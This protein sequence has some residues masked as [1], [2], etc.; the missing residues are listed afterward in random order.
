MKFENFTIHTIQGYIETIFI[1]EYKDKLLLLD[2]GCSSDVQLI[3]NFVVNTLKRPLTDIKLSFISHAH[4]DHAG[5]APILREKF[6]IQ[7]ASHHEID[8][9]Y[10]GFG[11]FLQQKTDIMLG[12]FVAIRGGQK[13]KLNINYSRTINPNHKLNNNDLLPG[14]RDWRAIHSPGHTSHDMVLYNE[15]EKILYAADIILKVGKKCVL[16]F[17]VPMPQLMAQSLLRLSHLDIK[18]LLLA[19]GEKCV[20]IDPKIIFQ[21][22]IVLISANQNIFLNIMKRFSRFPKEIKRIRKEI[23]KGKYQNFD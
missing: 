20:D 16:P 15:K 14:F 2:G 13:K 8:K 6:N 1:A 17:P 11:G 9:W 5:G 22:V 18:I 3:E 19:H 23:K 21:R 7:I 10:A 12:G 4:P